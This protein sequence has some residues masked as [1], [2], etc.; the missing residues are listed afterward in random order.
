MNRT[1]FK[2]G[3]CIIVKERHEKSPKKRNLLMPDAAPPVDSLYDHSATE[4]WCRHVQSY[5]R[6]LLIDS[7]AA[8]PDKR[9]VRIRLVK[10][11]A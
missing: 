2:G 9:G 8:C 11:A 1:F 6:M 3:V 7:L 5:R 4:L 10:K